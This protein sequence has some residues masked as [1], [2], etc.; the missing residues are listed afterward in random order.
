MAEQSRKAAAHFDLRGIEAEAFLAGVL[1]VLLCLAAARAYLHE[2]AL[3]VIGVIAFAVMSVLGVLSMTS[4]AGSR[5]RRDF[6]VELMAVFA[7]VWI[8]AG[9]LYAAEF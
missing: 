7:I 3:P 9:R 1:T 5:W 6:M 8:A 2:M 4:P